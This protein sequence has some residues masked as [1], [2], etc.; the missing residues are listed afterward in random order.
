V[1]GAR[2]DAGCSAPWSLSIGVSRYRRPPSDR[3]CKFTPSPRRSNG[4]TLSSWL[5]PSLAEVASDSRSWTLSLPVVQHPP[6]R[7]ES[8]RDR[9]QLAIPRRTANRRMAF[10]SA[11]AAIYRT[12][13]G[14]Y[15]V[16]R[17]ETDCSGGAAMVIFGSP[18]YAR[19][20]WAVPVRSDATCFGRHDRM[21]ACRRAPR[22]GYG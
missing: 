6:I 4:G 14:A 17:Q 8:E 12:T 19:A 11:F 15:L 20:D 10:N 18:K 13:V 9:R 1:N 2:A 21:S 7:D 16:C 3:T 5:P 22:D